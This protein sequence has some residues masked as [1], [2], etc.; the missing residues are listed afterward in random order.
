MIKAPQATGSDHQAHRL[1][2]TKSQ[3]CFLG[4][5]AASLTCSEGTALTATKL[6]PSPRLSPTG[7]LEKSD[8]FEL[9]IFE[10]AAR[11]RLLDSCC[12]DT[13]ILLPVA[14][15]FIGCVRY[16]PWYVLW[17]GIVFE[18]SY[19]PRRRFKR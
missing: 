6:Q 4:S 16:L 17:T 18:D 14:C 3:S 9:F 15:S 11:S 8:V 5:V 13:D 19:K 12:A 2:F 10:T 7:P 1:G